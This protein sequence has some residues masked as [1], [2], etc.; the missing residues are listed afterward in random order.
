[1]IELIR[2]F[3]PFGPFP[4]NAGKDRPC[5]DKG[6]SSMRGAARTRALH[7]AGNGRGIGTLQTLC[8]KGERFATGK[9]AMPPPSRRE[10]HL[11]LSSLCAFFPKHYFVTAG[12][13]TLPMLPAFPV[14]RRG[15]VAFSE[16]P[17]RRQ[18]PTGGSQQRALSRIFTGFPFHSGA[19]PGA[20]NRNCYYLFNSE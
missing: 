11:L 15:P 2:L 18:M 8:R 19:L 10:Y 14:R 13:L 1:V 17:R 6:A 12:L 5:C 3:L 4:P 16:A 7:G 9:T 20:G